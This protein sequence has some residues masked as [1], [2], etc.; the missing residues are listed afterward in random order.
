MPS[1]RVRRPRSS[2]SPLDIPAALLLAVTVVVTPTGATAEELPEVHAASKRP[3]PTRV[4]RTKSADLRAVAAKVRPLVHTP[5]RCRECLDA[6]SRA[7]RLP[8]AKTFSEPDL[9]EALLYR[10]SGSSPYD[11]V[12]VYGVTLVAPFSC[13]SVLGNLT[14]RGLTP[15]QRAALDPVCAALAEVVSSHPDLVAYSAHWMF[16]DAVG[17]AAFGVLLVDRRTR[18]VL[19]VYVIE[20][21]AD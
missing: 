13:S 11:F 7:Y 4:T 9:L 18:E 8:P 14:E 16:A 17:A 1:L 15:E 6:A 5:P 21:W 12:L 2:P 3:A 19:W 10:N 20:S